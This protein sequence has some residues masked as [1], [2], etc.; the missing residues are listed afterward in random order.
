MEI[1]VPGHAGMGFAWGSVIRIGLF[2]DGWKK[3]NNLKIMTEFIVRRTA[4]LLFPHLPRDLRRYHLSIL[5]II[6]LT[7]AFATQHWCSV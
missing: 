4:K 2:R 1:I 7:L 6:L 3:F 5:M